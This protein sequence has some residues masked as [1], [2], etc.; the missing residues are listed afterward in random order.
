MI[1]CVEDEPAIRN[2]MLYTLMAAG[3]EAEG[4]DSIK[5]LLDSVEERKPRLIILDLRLPWEKVETNLSALREDPLT[6]NV[7]IIMAS[8]KGLTRT[9]D[10]ACFC[11]DY[12]I[13]PFGMMEMLSHV[14]AVIKRTEPQSICRTY[15]LG[16]LTLD[17]SSRSVTVN[18]RKIKLTVKEYEILYL[19][20][21]EP[22]KIY[23]RSDLM[24]AVWGLTDIGETRTVDVHIATLRTKIG[25]ASR[26]IETVRGAGYRVSPE[27]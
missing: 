4:V 2:M 16:P 7:P 19:L 26:Y 8:S 21:Q 10:E 25:S 15:T 5:S 14:K 1:Y 9:E 12:I 24:K 20:L 11:D 17:S 23:S 6:R 13:K 18:G 22:G 27:R 3:Y